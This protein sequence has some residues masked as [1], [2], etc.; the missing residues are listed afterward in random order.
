MQCGTQKAEECLRRCVA[1]AREVIPRGKED[2]ENQ[3]K[4]E[5]MPVLVRDA[6]SA[7]GGSRLE[8][9]G[10]HRAMR[11]AVFAPRRTALQ[12]GKIDQFRRYLFDRRGSAR[13]FDQ[14]AMELI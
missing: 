9:R 7:V 4:I 10:I 13:S 8:A 14:I 2:A 12:I 6:E 11:S 3:M 5:K 1:R